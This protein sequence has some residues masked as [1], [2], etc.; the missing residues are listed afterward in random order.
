MRYREKCL[1]QRINI[2]SVCGA[3]NKKLQVHHIDGDRT[4]NDLEN[5]TPLCRDCHTEVH[6]PSAFVDDRIEE[7]HEQIEYTKNTTKRVETYLNPD[8]VEAVAELARERDT[9][10]SDVIRE[11]VKR[12]LQRH[13]SDYKGDSDE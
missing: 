12:E 9:S 1:K 3:S 2:C 13:H 7:L 5:L 4:N 11:A 8:D 10:S 6:R